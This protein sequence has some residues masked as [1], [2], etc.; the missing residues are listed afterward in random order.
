MTA[1]QIP[2]EEFLSWLEPPA[3]HVDVLEHLSDDE[4][5]E[6]LVRRFRAFSRRGHSWQRA[7]L[8]AVGVQRPL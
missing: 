1:V 8:L 7:V 3:L 6:L 4:V 5:E 2:F